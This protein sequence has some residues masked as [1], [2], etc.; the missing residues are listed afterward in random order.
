MSFLIEAVSVL[1]DNQTNQAAEL[2]EFCNSNKQTRS[3]KGNQ[4]IIYLQKTF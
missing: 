2:L 4:E 3:C 1:M